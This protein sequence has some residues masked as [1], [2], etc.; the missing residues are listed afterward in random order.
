MIENLKNIYA[1]FDSL[2]DLWT[3]TKLYSVLISSFS[4]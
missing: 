1:A 4:V 2:A 3:G